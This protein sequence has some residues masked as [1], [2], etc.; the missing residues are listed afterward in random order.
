MSTITLATLNAKYP[1]AAFGLRYLLANMGPLRERTRLL[2]FTINE[3]PLDVAEAI[4]ATNPSI[5]GLGVYIWNVEP[6]R[7]L[8]ELLRRLAPGLTL[9]VGGPEVSH[10]IDDQPW[11]A[12]VD[13]VIKGEGELAFAQLCTRLNAGQHP[14]TRVIDGGLPDLAELELPYAL[15]D[16]H[17]LRDR[18]LYVEASRG[19]PY[20]CEFCL[21]S[22]DKRVR[23]FPLPALL[24]AFDQLI[25]RGAR[26]FKFVDRTFN[27][28]LERSAAIL[29]FFLARVRPGLFLHFEMVPD[30]LPDGLRE[31]IAAFP[32]GSLQFEVGV[33]TLDDEVG[34]RI[35]RR[36][37]VA[38][39]FDNLA[40]LR[41]R[42][43]VHLHTDLIIG[44]PGETADS[45]GRG[46][47]QLV[48]ADVQEVQVGLLKRLRGTPISRHAEQFG[49]LFEPRPPYGIL[50]SHA[51]DFATMQRLRRFAQVWDS[52][53][54]RG[55]LAKGMRLLWSG[56]S[57]YERTLAFADW[58]FATAGRVHSMSLENRARYLAQHLIEIRSEPH[59]LVC[60]LIEADF[61]SNNRRA[62]RLARQ[63][64]RAEQAAQAQPTQLPDR[65]RRH[66]GH[67]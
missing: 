65:Q 17:D 66:L 6:T 36:Q 40:F 3:R 11:L 52:F 22:L 44:L 61:V 43:G 41:E 51:I 49:M 7:Q 57:P 5:V 62:P 4:L 33:Q 14:L 13:Y 12:E 26:Q 31:L 20:R 58:L 63:L 34:K 35:S 56:G 42:T 8:V 10:E 18:V 55:D 21:S 30:R 19:C 25:H 53:W 48:A 50:Q 67:A 15:Y 1:H 54:N 39:M 47:D 64:Q 24:A 46:L 45:F 59:D 23:A 9:V 16:D 38:R 60:E 28:D 37:N 27:L 29:E 32:A 2:E